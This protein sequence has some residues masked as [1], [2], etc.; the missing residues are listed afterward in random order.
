[1]VTMSDLNNPNLYCRMP[2]FSENNSL[3]KGSQ[4]LL[5]NLIN[6]SVMRARTKHFIHESG[7]WLATRAMN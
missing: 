5:Q 7:F 1:M 4:S 6:A 3:L 2:S